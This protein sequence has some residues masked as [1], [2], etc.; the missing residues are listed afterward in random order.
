MPI[1]IAG[2]D[3]VRAGVVAGFESLGLET[4]ETPLE[5][6]DPSRWAVVVGAASGRTL[7]EADGRLSGP[8][9][10]IELGGMG[11]RRVEDLPGVVAGFGSDGPCYRC[12]RARVAAADLSLEPA[13]PGAID[14]GIPGYAGAVAGWHLADDPAVEDLV[15]RVVELGGPTRR[16]LPVPGCR[17]HDEVDRGDLRFTH[18]DRPLEVVVDAMERT[19]DARL[20]IITEVGER[21]SHPAPYYLAELAETE[22]FSSVSAASMA[23]GVDLD[24]TAAFARAMGESLERYCAG[25]VRLD[26]LPEEPPG[27]QIPLERFA[28]AE[29][30]T[31]PVGRWWPART[32]DGERVALPVEVVSFPTPSDASIPSITTG[33]GLGSSPVEAT[34][35]G[36]LEVLERDACMLGWYSTYEPAELVV[37][38]ERVHRWRRRLLG[39]GLTASV[40]L[41]TQDVDVPVVTGI[42][43]R[44]AAD[45]SAVADVPGVDPDDW[46]RFAV[47]SAASLDPV[48][49]AERAIAEATQNW[50]EL[51]AM[52]PERA[53]SEGNIAT[54]AEFPRAARTFLEADHR[55]QA[56]HVARE[57]VPTGVD[58]LD[59]LAGRL[60]AAGMTAYVAR[61]TT[62]DV[63]SL[64]LEAV[65]VVVPEAQPLIHGDGPV[66]ERLREGPRELGFRPRLDRGPH[67]YP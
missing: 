23:A 34:L 2:P 3:E 64:G 56:A 52:G 61:T 48:V 53:R 33:L 51:E 7:P 12:L 66:A 31:T 35:R 32:L 10:G 15:G 24:W 13:Q 8:W 59:D 47:G 57:P 49:A 5:E 19:L 40:R 65:R 26:R 42:V 60:D 18:R 4:V 28:L 25:S 27:R 37:D 67:P 30:H 44:R 16:L 41:V 46:P 21:Q 55:L 45:G 38:D 36:L 9:V 39:V 17:C 54:F 6:V 58:A 62:P 1:P 43:H 14:D 63:A 50:M 11:G 20:G 29:G 22:G